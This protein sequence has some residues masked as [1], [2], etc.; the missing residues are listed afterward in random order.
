MAYTVQEIGELAFARCVALDE[1][2]IPRRIKV[3]EGNTFSGCTNLDNII[4][5]DN[6]KEIKG[7]A[8]YGCT[9]LKYILNCII[10]T[11]ENRKLFS[12][13][14]SLGRS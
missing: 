10:C 14:N 2:T 13:S 1:I 6:V 4:I 12:F 3:I 11:Q 8:F 9:K 7:F 5:P